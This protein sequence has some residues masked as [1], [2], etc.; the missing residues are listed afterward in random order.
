M[1]DLG[2]ARVQL[3]ER[4][5][6]LLELA[7]R[8]PHPRRSAGDA[9][10]IEPGLRLGA[11]LRGGAGEREARHSGMEPAREHPADG[12]EALQADAAKLGDAARARN[13]RAA[14]EALQ[15]IQFNIRAL[16]PKA[17]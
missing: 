5:V 10:G 15:R 11:I 6:P 3:I 7:Q 8:D 1:L 14:N 9:L 2:L 16:R 13:V 4:T 12:A 17:D